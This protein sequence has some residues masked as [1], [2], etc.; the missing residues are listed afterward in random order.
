VRSRLIA[1][2]TAVAVAGGVTACGDDDEPATVE[3]V[4]TTTTTT[5][6]ATTTTAATTSSTTTEATTT[7]EPTTTTT[8]TG[9]DV[10]GNCDEAEHADDPECT[11]GVE[12][13]GDDSSGTGSGGTSGPG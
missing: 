8:E 11:G 3:A 6:P 2:L 9:E 10:S 12:A 13:P 4:T 5:V 7:T 1:G